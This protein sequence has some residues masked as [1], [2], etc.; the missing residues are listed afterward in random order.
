LMHIFGKDEWF[1]FETNPGQVHYCHSIL[2]FP[3]AT[4]SKFYPL[5]KKQRDVKWSVLKL[6][7]LF[8]D[9]IIQVLVIVLSMASIRAPLFWCVVSDLGLLCKK[10]NH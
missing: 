6:S 7:Y 8:Y 3:Y 10:Y 9:T 2:I 1:I 5:A 4:S